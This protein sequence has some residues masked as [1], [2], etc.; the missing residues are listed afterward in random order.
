[1]ITYFCIFLVALLTSLV[2]IPP[3]SRLAVAIGVMDQ[4]EERKVHV[5]DTPRLGGIAIFF[6]FLLAGLLFFQFDQRTRG[7]LVGGIIIF[8]T[9]LADDLTGLS[10]KK[11]FIGQ[12]FAG[13]AAVVMVG[14]HCPI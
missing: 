7:F 13:L 3:I 14:R 2:M 12:F 8:L 9:G 1:M 6:G 4:T 5:N 11:K 10:P